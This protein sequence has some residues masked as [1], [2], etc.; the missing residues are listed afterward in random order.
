MVNRVA[1]V[2]EGGL[3]FSRI[4]GKS[5]F[6][7]YHW[8][9]FS[10]K[11]TQTLIA[12]LPGQSVFRQKS[13]TDQS[14]FMDALR[15][16]MLK[17]MPPPAVEEVVPPP[18]IALQQPR[19]PIAQPLSPPEP[20]PVLPSPPVVG[21]PEKEPRVVPPRNV[22]AK[23]AV[24]AVGPFKPAASQQKLPNRAQPKNQGIKPFNLIPGPNILPPDTESATEGKAGLWLIVFIIMSLSAWAG[25]E[26]AVFRNRPVK[27][28]CLLSALCPVI[29]PVVFLIWPK[30]GNEIEESQ[31]TAYNPAPDMSNIEDAT[32]ITELDTR[33]E[34]EVETATQIHECY[35]AEE[36]RFSG[37]FFADYLARFY[38]EPPEDGRA[39]VL[40]TEK[41]A[42]PV[43]HISDLSPESM[44][45]VYPSQEGLAETSIPY[46]H[47]QEVRVQTVQ[48]L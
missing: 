12:E 20:A 32:H 30:P 31:L 17:L 28:V 48:I 40:T 11:G 15:N 24:V 4:L 27:L 46:R 38:K 45:I 22:N 41:G 9:E 35:R 39:L 6:K 7:R 10:L 33:M 47:L 36:T 1:S 44:S 26:V 42:Y 34:T 37:K 13:R 25:H 8:G 16:Q 21:K 5:D 23:P 2:N 3:V 14:R 19:K 29:V 43:H 18:V